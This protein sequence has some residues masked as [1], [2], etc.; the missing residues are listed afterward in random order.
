MNSH[1]AAAIRRS[2]FPLTYF[3]LE[4]TSFDLRSHESEGPPYCPLYVNILVCDC[5]TKKT[6]VTCKYTDTFIHIHFFVSVSF[7]P[8]SINRFQLEKYVFFFFKPYTYK[9]IQYLYRLKFGKINNANIYIYL[10]YTS[11]LNLKRS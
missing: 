6:G 4:M 3:N 2:P 8:D 11:L 10:Q 7:L 9:L 5:V 1:Q